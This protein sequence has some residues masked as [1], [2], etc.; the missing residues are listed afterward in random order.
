[1][2]KHLTNTARTLRKSQTPHEAKL[3][4]LLLLK[5]FASAKFRRQ[6][7]IG[8]YIVDFCCPAKNVVIELDGG[9]HVE[10]GQTRMDAVRDAFL[11]QRGYYVL[12]IWNHELM[13]NQAEV[14]NSIFEIVAAPSPPTPL[15][16]RGEG[17]SF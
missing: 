15:P 7:P 10:D 2:R 5:R 1:M 16:R 12:R 9:G 8:N 4:S 3:W 11:R 6:Y 17:R 14:L 13:H